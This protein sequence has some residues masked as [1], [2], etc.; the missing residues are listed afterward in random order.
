MANIGK[1]GFTY[2]HYPVED[3][4]KTAETNRKII[5]Q[6]S[7]IGF[8]INL[9]ANDPAHAD[10]LHALDIAPVTTHLPSTTTTTT[11]TTPEGRKIIVC[12]ATRKDDVSCMTCKL[13]A[14]SYRQSIVGFPAHGAG[15]GKV[16][17]WLQSISN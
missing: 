10:R 6:A 13:C 3:N 14:K 11:T 5:Q 16:D 9:S 12:P 17:Q 15:K 1:R 4:S 8:V 2:T 7:E